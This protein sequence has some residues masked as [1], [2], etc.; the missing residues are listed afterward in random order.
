MSAS[1]DMN[2]VP[3]PEN[4]KIWFDLGKMF[5]LIRYKNTKVNFMAIK[6]YGKSHKM[7][8]AACSISLTSIASVLDD[9]VCNDYPRNIHVIKVNDVEV[10]L[11][12]V[13]YNFPN[14]DIDDT[15]EYAHR[16]S[17]YNKAFYED[18]KQF[19]EEYIAHFRI[20]LRDVQTV[21]LVKKN[22]KYYDRLT[23]SIS[24]LIKQLDKFESMFKEAD[25]IKRDE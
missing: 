18:D 25:V 6:G 2:Y 20:F 5:G 21:E 3:R 16:Q 8:N 7:T 13:F 9:M 19:I 14:P 22:K 10:G 17:K 24:K 23:K 15:N 11:T 4:D 1:Y 12:S